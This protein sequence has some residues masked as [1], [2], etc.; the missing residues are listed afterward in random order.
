MAFAISIIKTEDFEKWMAGFDSE[1]SVALR[2]SWGETSH[3]LFRT[4]DDPNAVLAFWEWDSLEHLREFSMSDELRATMKV[5]GVVGIPET[6]YLEEV[7]GT[8]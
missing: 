8:T 4:V 6:Y 3:R 2:K 1:G 7:K 5:T